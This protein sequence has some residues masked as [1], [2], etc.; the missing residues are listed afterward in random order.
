MQYY[1]LSYVTIYNKIIDYYI[2]QTNKNFVNE[3]SRNREGLEIKKRLQNV[4][5]FD[6][7]GFQIL[8]A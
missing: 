7:N 2:K 8:I 5:K 6:Y 4:I 3:R 1:T